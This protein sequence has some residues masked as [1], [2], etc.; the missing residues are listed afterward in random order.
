[1]IYNTLYCSIITHAPMKFSVL[2]S[3]T[4]IENGRSFIST[5]MTLKLVCA[6]A[7]SVITYYSTMQAQLA[8]TIH[9]LSVRYYANGETKQLQILNLGKEAEDVQHYTWI[10]V[11]QNK[12]VEH[13]NIT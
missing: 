8:M 10:T 7:P 13:D 2:G 11:E 12:T 1:M 4:E 6:H 3:G 9:F 5:E